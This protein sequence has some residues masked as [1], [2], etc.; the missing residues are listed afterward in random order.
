MAGMVRWNLQNLGETIDSL[1]EERE[2]L[3]QERGRMQEQQGRVGQ[4]W[5]SSAGT[6]Y[7]N[8]LHE[9]MECLE[10]ILNQLQIRIDSLRKVLRIYTDAE[11]IIRRAVQN[12][13]SGAESTVSSVAG[14]LLG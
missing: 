10:N 8:R 3:A 9:D 12:I 1:N 14:N 4:N 13:N 11:T 6:Q 7:Q 5:Q 2:R